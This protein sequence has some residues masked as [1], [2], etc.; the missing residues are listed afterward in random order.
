M[1]FVELANNF[2]SKVEVS[3]GVLTV[4]AKSIMSVMRLAGTQG[5]TLTIVA[6]GGDAEEACQALKDLVETGFGEMDGA[7]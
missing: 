3:N 7:F 5:T 2:T 6:D 4:D 1:Q